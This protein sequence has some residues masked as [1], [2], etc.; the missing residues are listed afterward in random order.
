MNNKDKNLIMILIIG[1]LWETLVESLFGKKS[2][3]TINAKNNEYYILGM[4]Y[5][6]KENTER[7]SIIVVV[8]VT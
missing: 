7:E 1:A 8:V 3:E 5:S 4:T 2:D 6:L